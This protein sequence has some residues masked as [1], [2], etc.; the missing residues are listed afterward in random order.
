MAGWFDWLPFVGGD[1]EEEDDMETQAIDY[2]RKNKTLMM[3]QAGDNWALDYIPRS[4]SG[5]DQAQWM[6]LSDG[7]LSVQRK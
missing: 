1:D 2:Y 3:N 4:L 5:V 6:M 7:K